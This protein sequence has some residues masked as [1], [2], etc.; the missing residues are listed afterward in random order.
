MKDI[1][2]DSSGWKL[3]TC[4]SSTGKLISGEYAITDGLLFVRTD[5]GAIECK[6]LT[7]KWPVIKIAGQMLRQLHN[8]P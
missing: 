4:E 8:K 2:A 1:T 5:R 6:R 3:F 7:G